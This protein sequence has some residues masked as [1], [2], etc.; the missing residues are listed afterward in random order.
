MNDKKM[1]RPRKAVHERKTNFL[2]IRLEEDQREILN[3]VAS[4]LGED[5]STWAR[6]VLLDA[7]AKVLSKEPECFDV[8]GIYFLRS[9][10]Q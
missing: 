8:N 10:E 2:R 5:T 3:T 6:R 7:A 9:A 1:S 4:L